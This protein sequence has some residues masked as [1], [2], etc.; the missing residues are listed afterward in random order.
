MERGAARSFVTA[1]TGLFANVFG[2]EAE[3][4]LDLYNSEHSRLNVMA[5]ASRMWFKQELSLHFIIT[6]KPAVGCREL[7]NL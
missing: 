5:N 3:A 1:N 4:R 7:P 6:T 2:L